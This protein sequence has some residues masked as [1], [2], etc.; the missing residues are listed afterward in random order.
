M[1]QE[2]NISFLPYRKG[3]SMIRSYEKLMQHL[4]REENQQ[5]LKKKWEE[6][7]KTRSDEQ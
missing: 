7:I 3:G 5:E 4:T 2:N 1:G 6:R